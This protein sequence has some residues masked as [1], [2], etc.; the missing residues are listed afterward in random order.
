MGQDRRAPKPV[1]LDVPRSATG[2]AV[3]TT[4]PARTL[5]QRVLHTGAVL[6]TAVL[7]GSCA[8][9]GTPAPS[10]T[11]P[12]P[13][14]SATVSSAPA[15]S[16]PPPS[17]NA[18]AS[19]EPAR[20][21]TPPPGGVRLVAS[22]PMPSPG[23]VLTAFGSVWVTNGPAQT[24]TRLDPDT[25]AV[26]A[27]IPTPGPA[28]VVGVGA[29]AVWVT[30]FPGNSLTRIDPRN[31]RVTRTISLAPGGAGPIGVTVFDGFVWVANH[32]GDPTT[33]VSKIDPT[34]MH[35]VDVIPVGAGSDAGPVWILSS[36]GSIWTDVNSSVNVVVRIDPRS[37]RTLA[38]IPAP[39]ACTQLAADDTAVWGASGDDESCTPS[40]SR[41]DP[42]TNKVVATIDESGAADAVALYD[43]SLWYGT[44]ATHKLVRVET[45]TNK[46]VSQLDL[47]GPAFGMTGG[48][49]AIWVTDRDDGTL[50]KIDP[51]AHR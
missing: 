27:L 21:A 20:T 24:V 41:I 40:V 30:S 2:P 48:A 32:D 34:T 16:S 14:P 11:S 15:S 38:S 1:G 49:G 51:G 29:G 45:R 10:A 36:A 18:T 23:S 4:T 28:S 47:P 39:S 26:I 31:N 13:S 22:I 50:F 19:S 6:A 8:G 25:N 7:L 42:L 12:P 46:V 37:D 9:G 44:T 3:G 17:P 33:S 5:R 43:G 35:V